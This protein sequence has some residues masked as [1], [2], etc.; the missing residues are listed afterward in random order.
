MLHGSFTGAGI[1]CLSFIMRVFSLVKYAVVGACR[2]H[3]IEKSLFKTPLLDCRIAL[4][5][6]WKIMAC[7]LSV[8]RQSATDADFVFSKFV[9][10]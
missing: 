3:I 1:T 9:Y 8:A 5:S 7:S 6:S 10:G 2:P 4:H